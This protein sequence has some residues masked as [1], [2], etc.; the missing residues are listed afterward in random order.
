MMEKISRGFSKRGMALLLAICMVCSMSPPIMAAEASMS[1]SGNVVL[2]GGFAALADEVREQSVPI[3]TSSVELNLPDTLEATMYS[4]SEDTAPVTPAEPSKPEPTEPEEETP[5]IIGESEPAPAPSQPQDSGEVEE[6]APPADE[7]ES[8]DGGETITQ[9]LSAYVQSDITQA[10]EDTTTPAAI[11]VQGVTWESNPIYAEDIAG[12]YKFTALLP[13]GYTVGDGASLPT[14]AVTVGEV[15][16]KLALRTAVGET[17]TAPI[18]V[19]GNQVDCTFMVLTE[20]NVDGNGGTVQIG[21]GRDAAINQSSAGTLTIPTTIIDAETG[22]SYTVTQIGDRAFTN[23]YSLS[24]ELVIPPQITKIGERAFHSCVELTGKLTIPEGVTTLGKFAF[25]ACYEFTELSLPASLTDMGEAAFSD[26]V[27]IAKFSVAAGNPNYVVKDTFLCSKDFTTLF[28]CPLA[29][30]EPIAI[31]DTVTR[32]GANAFSSCKRLTAPPT[33]PEGVTTIGDYA[34]SNCDMMNGQLTIPGNVTTIGRGA[35][36]NC[37]Q[38]TGQLDIPDSVITIDEGAFRGCEGLTGLTLGSGVTTVG[39]YAFRECTE[40][41]GTLIIPSTINN[42][43]ESAFVTCY[44][45]TGLTIES[46]NTKFQD[47]AFSGCSKLP[48]VIFPDGTT[49]IAPSLFSSCTMLTSVTIPESV[50]K[51]GNGAFDYCTSLPSITI[52]TGVTKIEPSTFSQCTSLTEITIPDAVTFIDQMAFQGCTALTSV[53]ILDTNGSAPTLGNYAFSGCT[54]LNTLK[55]P[56]ATPPP[57]AQ[58]ANK[59]F[60]GV[61]ASNALVYLGTDGNEITDETQ[62]DAAAALYKAVPDGSTTDKLWRGWAIEPPDAVTNIDLT[63]NLIAPAMGGTPARTITADDQ[64]TGTVSWSPANNPFQVNTAYTAT[65]TLTAEAGHT[66]TGVTQNSFT[67]TGATV[68]NPAGS[69]NSMVVTIVFPTLQK[70]AGPAVSGVAAVNCTDESNNDG[71]LTGVT[72]AME[73]KKTDA[74]TYAPGTG[75]TITGL[76]PGEYLVRVKETTTHSAGANSS[77]TVAAYSPTPTYKINLDKTGTYPF[78]GAEFGYGAQT[79]LT[80]TVSNAG[81]QATGAL[82]AALS[83]TNSGSFTLSP[84]SIGSIAVNGNSTFTVKPNTGLAA[85]TYTATVTVSGG[86]SITAGF[87]VSFTV[88]AVATVP[89]TGV[90]V[91][92]GTATIEAGKTQQL[93]ASVVP[94]NATTKAVTWASDKTAIATV[95]ASGLVTAVAEGTATIT[96]TA[97]DGSG[98]IGSC[99]VTITP[100]VLLDGTKNPDYITSKVELDK[101]HIITNVTPTPAD[102]TLP[103]NWS[104]TGDKTAKLV[105]NNN[106][107]GNQSFAVK[108]T[109]LNPNYADVNIAAQP[110]PVSTVAVTM[111]KLEVVTIGTIGGTENLSATVTVTGAALTGDLALTGMEWRSSCP[112]IVSLSNVSM[113]GTASVTAKGDAKGVSMVG[114]AYKNGGMLGYVLVKVIDNRDDSANTIDQIKDITDTLDKLVDKDNPTAGDKGAVNAVADEV[115][116]LPEAAKVALTKE[117][118]ESLDDLKKSVNNTL[119]IT[120]DETPEGTAPPAPTG[121]TAVGTAIA[122]GVDSGTV[123][124]YVTPAPTAADIKMELKLDMAVDSAKG[125]QLQAPLFFTMTLPS[126]VDTSK[127]TIKHIKDGGATETVAFTYSG[128]TVSFKLSSFSGLQFVVADTPTPPPSGGDSSG[129]GNS[130][131][132]Q[133]DFWGKVKDKINDA[134]EGDTIKVN[135]KDYDKMPE[136]VMDTLRKNPDITIVIDWNGGELI[137][138]PA[139]KAQPKEPGRIYWPL[140]L[141]VELYKGI[142]FVEM[143]IANKTNPETGGPGYIEYADGKQIPV[144]GG[145]KLITLDAPTP[146]IENTLP[147]GAENTQA[148]TSTQPKAITP[149]DAGFEQ[150]AFAGT[151]DNPQQATGNNT[152]TVIALMLA[153]AAVVSGVW[154]WKRHKENSEQT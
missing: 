94:E 27:G 88:T 106:N 12:T 95:D 132:G 112:E 79:P 107:S 61:P 97:K 67:Y 63:D 143:P 137:T 20:P 23:C 104:F 125:K 148:I 96:A 142:S 124:Y 115:T 6:P 9:V 84:T 117:D 50:V 57:F 122:C 5:P 149:P 46:S 58:Y 53:T 144:T 123:T 36:S 140:S 41:T 99:A 147:N 76:V 114:V 64:Y 17:F 4:V 11:T 92:P 34:F 14:I 18:T 98:K 59:V 49:E 35:F 136:S 55:V 129:S 134:D 153:A 87:N 110:F 150:D 31:P 91:A 80:V 71:K 39:N 138:I 44:G 48:S 2:L 33:I 85:G 109:S 146:T 111:S 25:S 42:V 32:I 113:G 51:I 74:A 65:V 81:N 43:G 89:V 21:H 3:G 40:L 70:P 7:P 101:I 78:T 29:G 73:Y 118:V 26:C 19:G 116:K 151:P 102:V 52:P 86:N 69:G 47:L 108:Y 121:V 77:F 127:L 103:A 37:D 62:L 54:A 13:E 66:F 126:G 45:L 128:Q 100:K 120:I 139:G 28:Q 82:T 24:D 16:A 30:T 90:T 15:P 1:D 152:L 131:D 119:T 130:D 93:T 133:Y 10:D 68:T 105:A 135:A 56:A 83:G 141:L 145:G 38:L 154:F 60:E 22:N 8:T 72:A 75:S